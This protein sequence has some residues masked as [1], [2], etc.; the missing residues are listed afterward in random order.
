MHRNLFLAKAGHH[1]LAALNRK[2]GTFQSAAAILYDSLSHEQVEIEPED[3]AAELEICMN[4]QVSYH[5]KS[6]YE[7]LFGQLPNEQL[8]DD[9][10]P[11]TSEKHES[12]LPFWPAQRA[13][14]E[15]RKAPH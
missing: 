13:R 14:H 7:A 12:E 6:P 8:V 1:R 3:L 15:A 2:C 4:T 9:Y 5:G 10:E 11:T